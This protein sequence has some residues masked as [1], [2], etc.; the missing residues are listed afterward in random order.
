MLARL[1]NVAEETGTFFGRHTIVRVRA[2]VESPTSSIATLSLKDKLFVEWEVVASGKH[3]FLLCTL[4]A[5]RG[6]VGEC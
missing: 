3:F 6:E 5:C 2:A 1:Q 4:S